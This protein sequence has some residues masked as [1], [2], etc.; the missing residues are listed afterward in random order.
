MKN[1]ANHS[2]KRRRVFHDDNG[3]WPSQPKTVDHTPLRMRTTPVTRYLF[4]DELRIHVEPAPSREAIIE[5]EP[6]AAL[7]I[8]ATG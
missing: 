7:T 3:S 5:D 8:T 4:D 1:L 6:R 2:A